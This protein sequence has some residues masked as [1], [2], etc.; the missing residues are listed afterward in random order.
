MVP[1]ITK[2]SEKELDKVDRLKISMLL[3]TCHPENFNQAVVENIEK[4]F[5]W[6]VYKWLRLECKGLHSCGDIFTHFS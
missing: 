2:S 1:I 3:S 5:L 4:R 6:W